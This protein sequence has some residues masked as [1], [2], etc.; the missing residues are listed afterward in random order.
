MI[1]VRF[2]DPASRVSRLFTT[3]VFFNA[4]V[5]YMCSRLLF[6]TQAAI[7]EW[8]AQLASLY[9]ASNITNENWL[10]Y[11]Q[12]CRAA[13]DDK[14]LMRLSEDMCLKGLPP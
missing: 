12:G 11:Q 2:F 10:A 13:Y 14:L 6:P 3:D 1:S 9:A 5:T 4:G 8:E 7:R